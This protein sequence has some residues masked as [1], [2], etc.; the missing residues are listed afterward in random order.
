[1][2]LNKFQKFKHSNCPPIVVYAVN[3]NFPIC[4]STTYCF[5]SRFENAKKVY[6]KLGQHAFPH[7]F[8]SSRLL[9]IE[10]S[11]ISLYKYIYFGQ[12][13]EGTNKGDGVGIKVDSDGAIFEGCWKNGRLNGFGRHI[14]NYGAYYIGE[15]KDD[16]KQG[17]GTLWRSDSTKYVG[18]WKDGKYHGK[19]V[20]YADDGQISREGVWADNKYVGKG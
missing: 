2:N 5:R 20:E 10:K 3:H 9:Q 4:L 7:Q 13:A 15:F 16:K 17:Q 14:Y 12:L 19:G 18:E 8:D 1:M 6:L 11:T